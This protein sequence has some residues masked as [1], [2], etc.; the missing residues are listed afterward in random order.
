[1]IKAILIHSGTPLTHRVN[2]DGSID[3]TQDYPS[4]EQGYGRIS[5]AEVLNFGSSSAANL[6]LFVRG[7]ARKEDKYF[8]SFTKAGQSHF[9]NF[10]VSASPP[11]R[12][13]VTVVYTDFPAMP[14]SS[15]MMVNVL[16]TKVS[17]ILTG[18]TYGRING[19]W[20]EDNVMV[21]DIIKPIAS[22]SYIVEVFAQSLTIE[23]PYALVMT[24]DIYISPSTEAY[25]ADIGGS[26]T[27]S[28]LRFG[29]KILMWGVCVLLFCFGFVEYS[30][31]FQIKLDCVDATVSASLAAEDS[32]Q[33]S[34]QH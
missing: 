20:I 16:S 32:T 30:H 18:E 31:I 2:R 15:N 3:S 34:M 5:I 9:Y 14:S 27:K 1:M 4:V 17:N 33:L 23:Q 28:L 19:Q 12:I 26:S 21:V 29:L 8:A 25:E 13:R 6:T 10:S 24:G 7:S 11:S 22:A